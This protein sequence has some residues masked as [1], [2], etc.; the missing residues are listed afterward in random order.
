MRKQIP[1]AVWEKKK[2]MSLVIIAQY[3]LT[4]FTNWVSQRSICMYV[5]LRQIPLT[6]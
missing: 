6:D 5:F 2:K 1:Q 4:S 3:L